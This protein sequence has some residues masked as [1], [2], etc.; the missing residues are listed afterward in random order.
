MDAVEEL[1]ILQPAALDSRPT[2]DMFEDTRLDDEPYT[3]RD[4]P[5]VFNKSH[6]SQIAT[7]CHIRKL[8]VETDLGKVIGKTELTLQEFKARG[9]ALYENSRNYDVDIATDTILLG[10][11]MKR[12]GVVGGS[13]KF[14]GVALSSNFIQEALPF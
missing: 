4:D 1:D 11:G 12:T 9:N 3:F 14:N 6:L 13:L 8:S 2:N 5:F 10:D 7:L